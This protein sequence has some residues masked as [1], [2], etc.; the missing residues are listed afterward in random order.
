MLRQFYF[1]LFLSLTWTSAYSYN[2]SSKADSL[3]IVGRELRTENQIQ[4]AINLF[5]KALNYYKKNDDSV[6]IA[7]TYNLLGVTYKRLG[8]KK[9][10]VEFYYSAIAIN[11]KLHNYEDLIKNYN[12]LANHYDNEESYSLAYKYYKNAENLLRY[13]DNLNYDANLKMNLASLFSS[14]GS[15]FYDYDS[16]LFYNLKSLKSFQQLNDSSKTSDIYHNLGVLHER[17]ENLDAALSNYQ[18]SI[19]ISKRLGDSL[20]L[21]L[22]LFGVGNIFLAQKNYPKSIEYYYKCIEINSAI[23]YHQQDLNLLFN[24]VKAKMATGDATE[25]EEASVLFQEYNSLRDSIYDKEKMQ[26]VKN[27]ETKYETAKKEEEIRLQ[28]MAIREKT[29]QSNLFLSLSILLVVL[30]VSAVFFFLQKQEYV[31]KLKN[32]EI[33]SMRREQELNEL[34]AMMHGQEEERNRIANDLHDRLGARLSSIKLLFQSEDSPDIKFKVLDSINEAIKETR[35]ISHNLS[36]DMLTRFGIETAINDAIRN[37]NESGQ[38]HADFVS[39]GLQQRLP[40][41]VERN[42][43]HVTLELINNTL[44]HAN[45][46]DIMIQISFIDDEINVFYEDDGDGFDIKKVADSGMGLRGIY[47]RMNSIKGVANINS[48]PGHGLNVVLSIPL[49]SD[50]DTMVSVKKENLA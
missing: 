28:E 48:R 30:I 16:A 15:D 17:N 19:E 42:I 25:L 1:I 32:E 2:S 7:K 45:A 43:Y 31:K 8:N 3:I 20:D 18:Q 47:A 33:A 21:S 37:I 14:F 22:T 24:L 44:K 12:N 39:Y 29:F 49:Q 4:E 23:N 50:T 26:E 35:E 11:E 38:I 6:S 9:K 34:N 27:L 36:T 40:L 5:E 46:S 13:V 10:T 41:E